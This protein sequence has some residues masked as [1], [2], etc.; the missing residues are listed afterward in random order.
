MKCVIQEKYRMP[1]GRKEMNNEFRALVDELP[2]LLK[3]LLNSSLRPWSD[4]GSLP[5]RG[6][7][8]FFENG[9]PI[10]VGRTNRM[11]ERI[12]EHG[13]SS[14][15]HNS[16]TFAFNLAKE[17]AKRKGIDINK[18]RNQLEKGPDF[19]NLFREARER[20]SRMSVRVIEID[21]P[22]V[23]TLFEVYA[24]IALKTPYNDFETH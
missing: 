19:S 23:Q 8:V 17:A 5:R 15:G 2:G 4:L 21:D 10:Y 9:R 7:Y 16:A 24:S 18:D 20:V 12:K 22:I 11:K 1:A 6:I 14:S 3:R 13:R